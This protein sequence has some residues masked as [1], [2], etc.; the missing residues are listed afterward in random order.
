MKQCYKKFACLYVI[1]L[2]VCLFFLS[3]RHHFLADVTYSL[4]NVVMFYEDCLLVIK[5]YI[6]TIPS[7][8][9]YIPKHTLNLLI[10]LETLKAFFS[11]PHFLARTSSC[12]AVFFWKSTYLIGSFIV[13][14]PSSDNDRAHYFWNWKLFLLFD[15]STK[16]I[17]LLALVFYEKKPTR[18]SPLE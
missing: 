6:V 17:R 15:V 3:T 9:S 12:P 7:K 10:S 16:T 11:W 1:W 8:R 2:L 4:I 5:L 18:L 14:Y 13:F